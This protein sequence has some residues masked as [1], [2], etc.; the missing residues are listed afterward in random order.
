MT[1]I[2][3]DLPLSM[4]PMTR[5]TV[6]GPQTRE[7]LMRE[8]LAAG[9]DLLRVLQ[10]LHLH[11]PLSSLL[12][13]SWVLFPPHYDTLDACGL[14]M[15]PI[16]NMYT[17]LDRSFGARVQAV[18]PHLTTLDT[19]WLDR[20]LERLN[21]YPVH[22]SRGSIISSS[23]PLEFDACGLLVTDDGVSSRTQLWH[24]VPPRTVWTLV[25]F[26]WRVPQHTLDR[27][28]QLEDRLGRELVYGED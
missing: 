15:D 9:K 16:A 20:R 10:V 23:L 8:R 14:T 19:E 28:E 26:R 12:P 6:P 25:T 13:Y 11:Q 4:D 1:T 21:P 2:P 5:S 17:S 24:S 22:D 18:P 7:Q 3:D 27:L